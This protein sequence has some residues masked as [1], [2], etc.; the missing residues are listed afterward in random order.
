MVQDFIAS[1]FA[2][3]NRLPKFLVYPVSA[4]EF[5]PCVLLKI[6]AFGELFFMTLCATDA[7]CFPPE[8][9]LCPPITNGSVAMFQWIISNIQQD[10]MTLSE[11]CNNKR[12]K[13]SPKHLLE[14]S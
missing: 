1:L 13:N 9:S 10:L 5:L 8:V 12:R 14:C 11:V 4:F 7:A 6:L 2:L 3:Y